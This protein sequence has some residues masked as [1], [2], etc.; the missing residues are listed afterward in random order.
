MHSKHDP[1]PP[2]A[3]ETMLALLA[4][5]TEFAAAKPWEYMY[6]SDVVGLTDSKTGELRLATVLG[7]AGEVF[8]AVFYRR[9]SG[10]RWLLT[11]LNDPED[12]VNAENIG[13]MDALKVELL[14]KSELLKEDL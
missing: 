4:A 3:R 7:N 10:L 5:T 9:P 2:I 14:R 8:G 13:A 12:C 6:D 1:P 11:T